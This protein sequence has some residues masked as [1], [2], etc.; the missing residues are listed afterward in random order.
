MRLRVGTDTFMRADIA[1]KLSP[2]RSLAMRK[3]EP[4]VVIE[5]IATSG[6]DRSAVEDLDIYVHNLCLLCI[7]SFTD[8]L[9]SK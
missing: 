6:S 4:R 7:Y 9:Q 3:S 2:R 5:R 1:R 8:N